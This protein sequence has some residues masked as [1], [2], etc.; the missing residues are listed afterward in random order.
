MDDAFKKKGVETFVS[1][2][3]WLTDK[4][5]IASDNKVKALFAYRLTGRCRPKGKELPA[6]EWRGKNNK[7]Y[8]L[9]Y[10]IKSFSDRGDYKKMRLFLPRPRVGER[11]RQQLCQ[12]CGFGVQETGGEVLPLHL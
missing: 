7:P 5:Y 12:F 8:E 4:G 1:F 9:I 6:I 3:N 10:I 11:P 2:I